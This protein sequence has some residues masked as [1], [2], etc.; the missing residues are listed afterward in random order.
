MRLIV[1]TLVFCLA[2]TAGVSG[3]RAY[4]GEDSELNLYRTIDQNSGK[5]ESRLMDKYLKGS[6]AKINKLI[7]Q[8]C[9]GDGGSP[10]DC[11]SGKDFKQEDLTEILEGEN[12]VAKL[13]QYMS[14]AVKDLSTETAESM[15]S[16]LR[17]YRDQ[18]TRDAKTER[19]GM[20][21]FGSV[22][23]FADGSIE[24]S[25]YDLMY[26]IEQINKILFKQAPKYGGVTNSNAGQTRDILAGF[27]PE[28]PEYE[29]DPEETSASTLVSEETSGGFGTSVTSTPVVA[30]VIPSTLCPP[31]NSYPS[32][33]LTANFIA[34]P[35]VTAG[36]SDEVPVTPVEPK[37]P[38]RSFVHDA[39]GSGLKG[40]GRTGDSFSCKAD[41]IVCIEIEFTMYKSSFGFGGGAEGNSIEDVLDQN[42]KILDK[43]S[44]SSFAQ[45]RMTNNFF[46]LSLKDIDLPSMAHITAI[47]TKKPPPILNLGKSGEKTDA[48]QKADDEKEFKE[49]FSRTFDAFG[50]DY[51][52][53]NDLTNPCIDYQ[54]THMRSLG[55]ESAP[56]KLTSN[57][58][59]PDGT[60]EEAYIDVK[61]SQMQEQYYE[62]FA[63]DLNELGRFIETLAGNINS[64]IG[65][66]KGINA[67]PKTR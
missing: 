13:R 30:P 57:S 8:S 39:A 41:Q 29:E 48:D 25:G 45:A 63:K 60:Q 22:G 49:I 3:A 21:K 66:I 52:R 54:I 7:G 19:R 15:L 16:Q 18:L 36:S 42:L 43:Y 44:S 53:Q 56:D 11:F 46:E 32:D 10:I 20:E 65:V 31:A 55:T 26:D 58:C 34:L 61:A 40:F 37:T 14:P 33:F 23:L 2:A 28:D 9:K 24:N 6:G 50:L 67:I 5:L 17:K 38:T 1:R 51:K 62:G 35:A 4:L 64:S 47:L 27:F 12:G 59:R